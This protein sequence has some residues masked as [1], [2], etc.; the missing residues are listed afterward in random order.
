MFEP[1]RPVAAKKL[2]DENPRVNEL[3]WNAAMGGPSGEAQLKRMLDQYT[4]AKAL[5]PDLTLRTFLLGLDEK[6]LM[7]VLAGEKVEEKK[8]DEKPA[9]KKVAAG[10]ASAL[11]LTNMAGGIIHLLFLLQVIDMIWKPGL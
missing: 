4:A 3:L 11:K 8:P 7:K 1:G 5:K 6:S 2:M 10:D 9:E